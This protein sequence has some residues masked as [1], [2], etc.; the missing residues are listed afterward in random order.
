MTWTF[1][2]ACR[3]PEP[4]APQAPLEVEFLGVGGYRIR[5]GEHAVLTP[6]MYSNPLFVDTTLGTIESDPTVVER[7][8][9]G[10][11]L[12][13]VRTVLVGHA[14]YDHLLDLPALWPRMPQATV[15]GNASMA[16]ILAAHAPDRATRCPELGP[17]SPE[18]PRER[19]VA[20]EGREWIETEDGAVRFLAL[21]SEH[22]PQFGDL[23]FAP[24]SVEADLCEVP[25][26]AEGWL[27]GTTLAY[28]VDFL[29]ARGE[30]V[31]RLYYQ[32]APADPPL[33]LPATELLEDVPVDVALLTVG[34]YIALAD[35][36][37]ATLRWLAPRYTVG[38]HWEDFFRTQ[39]EPFVPLFGHDLD[40]YAQG[41]QEGLP[42]GDEP[43]VTV[44][45]APSD[46][47]QWV[48][49]PGTTFSFPARE[50]AR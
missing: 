10:L 43:A 46:E 38:G 12:E 37:R 34:T 36:P 42:P 13:D 9:A 4:A 31:H 8:S 18:I 23:H 15:Y 49:V 2:L 14:H 47:R 11:E 24:G 17:P 7:F 26:E 29:D 33:G 32:D 16:H 40:E 50:P 20:L 25:A 39:D 28:L 3:E 22:P 48:P 44:D 6:P 21:R 45:G 27:E 30:V 35:H 1:L 5:Y 19:V 41:A